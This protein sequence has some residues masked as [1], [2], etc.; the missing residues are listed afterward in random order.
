M[1]M[2]YSLQLRI[3]SV[4]ILFFVSLLGMVVPFIYAASMRGGDDSP[5]NR[6]KISESEALQIARTFAAGVM[7]GIGFIHLLNDGVSKLES[8]SLDYPALGYTLATVGAMVVLGFEQI[9][10]TLVNQIK[11]DDV[12]PRKAIGNNEHAEFGVV[13]AAK[14]TE[15]VEYTH[16][17]AHAHEHPVSMI[18]GTTSLSVVV[19]AYMMELSIAVHSVV[20]G[21]ALGSMA[22]KENE[23]PLQALLIGVCFHQFFEGMGLGCVV[24]QARIELGKVKVILFALTF[25]LTVPVG[26]FVGILITDD[27]S[28]ENGPTL[29]ETLTAGC[30][31]SI[32]AGIVIYVALV[33]MVVDDFQ[34][35]SI[36]G[37]IPLKLK[38]FTALI[39]GNLAMAILVIWA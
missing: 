31:N 30:L 29:D 20:I 21:V 14:R 4:F 27:Q 37:N 6:L 38:M 25:A 36:V 11:T 33:E 26:V 32:A 28:L 13:G 17:H 1:M 10:L 12:A 8:V 5:E 23:Q 24:D 39:I 9:A 7:M 35:A 19:K 3:S 15:E 22:G 34:A 18:S 16:E 2:D